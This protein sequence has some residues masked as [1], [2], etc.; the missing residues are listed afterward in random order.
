LITPGI[1]WRHGAVFVKLGRSSSGKC[2][3]GKHTKLEKGTVWVASFLPKIAALLKEDEKA[4]YAAYLNSWKDKL[5]A[6][7]RK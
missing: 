5:E 6:A 7:T 3:M 2:N 4:K 1:D